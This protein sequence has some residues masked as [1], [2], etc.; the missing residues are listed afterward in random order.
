M[1]ELT[2]STTDRAGVEQQYRDS[3]RLRRRANIH[4]Y[5]Q[6]GIG[7]FEWVARE[8]QLPVGGAVLEVGC[9]PGWLW[10]Q[11]QSDAPADLRLTLTDLS[12]GMV[13]EARRRVGP[14]PRFA[15]AQ[16]LPADVMALPFA[17]DSFDAVL[18]CHMLYH[19]PD[20]ALALGEMLRVLRPGGRLAVTTN[21]EDNM[22]EMYA[23]AGAAFG[24]AT[25]DPS[26]LTF[27]LDRAEGM[28]REMLVGVEVATYRDELRVPDAEV[29]IATLTSYPPGDRADD[30]QIAAL[31]S[32]IEKGMA[33]GGGAFRIGKRLGLVRGRKAG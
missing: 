21:G 33:D 6:S 18:A 19:V 26:G 32:S 29:V 11:V 1:T 2:G 7:W 30:A 8:A 12:P 16:F 20:P 23:L 28:L 17:D 13:E 27:G 15:G 25:T 3:E 4:Q 5:G 9:G 24:G 10:E 22:A 31:R 14:L